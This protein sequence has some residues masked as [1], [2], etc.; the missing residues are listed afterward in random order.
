MSATRK[1]INAMSAAAHPTCAMVLSKVAMV[2]KVGE[3]RMRQK[4]YV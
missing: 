2:A 3:Y 1:D 4:V